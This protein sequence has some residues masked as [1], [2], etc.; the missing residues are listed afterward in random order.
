MTSFHGYTSGDNTSGCS[1]RMQRREGYR[2]VR[3]G[4]IRYVGNSFTAGSQVDGSQRYALSNAL[5]PCR[6]R[7]SRSACFLNTGSLGGSQPSSEMPPKA[8]TIAG[9][10]SNP[11]RYNSFCQTKP[12]ANQAMRPHTHKIPLD[13]TR[14]SS[15]LGVSMPGHMTSELCGGVRHAT[16][17]EYRAECIQ[18]AGLE[19]RVKRSS[20]IQ[21]G[22][23]GH[24]WVMLQIA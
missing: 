9:L 17:P 19:Y 8:T 1:T 23:Q 6:T 24:L 18:N 20:R 14:V 13:V 21:A 4:T 11:S 16:Q 10:P 12:R 22:E 3:R 5:K 2:R 7:I 15:H